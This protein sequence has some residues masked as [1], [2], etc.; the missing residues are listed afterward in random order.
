VT[1][2]LVVDTDPGV[3]DAFAL[4]LAAASP[5]VHLLAVTTV[6]GNVAADITAANA[7]R[8]LG[9]LGRPEVPIGRGAAEPLVHPVPESASL[10]HGEDG[11]GGRADAF[12]EPGAPVVDRALDV[13]VAVLESSPEPVVLAAIGPLT[14]VA[15]LLAVRPDLAPRIRRIVIMG[16]ALGRGGNVTPVAEFNV[17]SD[18]EAAHRVLAGS[19]VPTTLVPLDLT[20][21]CAVDERWLRALAVTGPI[22]EV[23]TGSSDHYLAHYHRTSG[24]RAVP[25]H[26]AIAMLEAVAPGSLRTTPL[27]IEV[28][29]STGPARGAVLADR[30][31]ASEDGPRRRVD[32]ALDADVDA[33]RDALLDRLSAAG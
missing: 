33:V 3:D 18:P 12:G 10:V 6:F 2:P 15:L 13:L 1:V 26:D 11:L 27:P 5:E 24:V 19:T 28:D 9:L 31:R 8:V 30:R 16:G 4:A 29:T 32:V 20:H 7:R 21:R 22:A 23:L 25:L 17:H 14:N